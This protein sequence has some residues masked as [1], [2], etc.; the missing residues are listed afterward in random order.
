M[1]SVPAPAPVTHFPDDPDMD[2]AYR[3]RWLVLTVL[4]ISVFMVVV[5]N[6]IINVA[7]PTLQRELDAT[8]TSLQ[9]IVDSYAL[10]FAGL[11]L[12]A[13][14]LGD[15]FGRKGSLQ[16]GLVLFAVFSAFAGFSDTSGEL[17]F[18]RGAMGVGA[19]F[20]FPATLAII[21]NLFVD[22]IERAK[23]IGVW[24]GVSGAAVAFGPVTGGFLLE[25][26]WWG[27]VF[28][29]NV[30]I[31]AIALV[32]GARFVP[33]SRSAEQGRLDGV[34]FLLSTAAIGVL[35][36]T[37]I[38]APHWGWTSAAT[39]GGFVFAASS[40]AAFV[41]WELRVEHPLLDVRVFRNLRFSAAT[42]AIGIAFF[43]LFGFTFLVTQYFQFVRGYDTLSAGLHTLPF[44]VG[45]GATA[46]VAAR[47]ALRFGTKKVVTAGLLNMSIGLVIIS[48]QDADAAYWGPVVISMLFL[49]NGLALVTSPSTDAVMGELPLDRAGVGSAVNDTSREVGGTLGVAVVGSVFVSLYGPDVL[50]R[51]GET[52]GLVENI[53]ADALLAAQDSVAAAFA[54]SEQAPAAFVDTIREAASGAFMGAFGTA[55]LVGAGAALAGA[56]LA[57]RY[58]PARSASHQRTT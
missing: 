37:V 10:V 39:L 47:L 29:I 33:R 32:L 23:A 40:L 55:C 24:S 17:I 11:L 16:I 22:P 45:A 9:W 44:A 7:L 8:T 52:P 12:A 21:T 43:V 49:A 42:S 46:P 20:V 28:F 50:D 5:D 2:R 14:G 36:F 27:S 19:A 48:Q 41:V 53:P 15:R 1:T 4:C 25:H 30:P 54:V 57:A 26:F 34:G 38:E 35:V 6:L 51:L 31:V 56:A 18:W 58:L 3:H 13:G